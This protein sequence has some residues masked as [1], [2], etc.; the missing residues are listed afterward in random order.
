MNDQKYEKLMDEIRSR[1][2]KQSNQIN[3][4]MD[5]TET[6][7]AAQLKEL[8]QKI[9]AEALALKTQR[10]EEMQQRRDELYPKYMAVRYA[11]TDT[12]AD[13]AVKQNL[14]QQAVEK[15]QAAKDF[16]ELLNMKTLAQRTGNKMLVQACGF[17]FFEQ[18]YINEAKAALAAGNSTREKEF[19]E[20]IDLT[21]SIESEQ[22]SSGMVKESFMFAV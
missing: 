5:L 6:A 8:R 19:D 4:N 2:E 12:E 16:D 10:R 17:V 22:L 15:A 20:L 21:F 3:S 11:P 9:E 13:K 14:Y 18:G 7:K 1:L